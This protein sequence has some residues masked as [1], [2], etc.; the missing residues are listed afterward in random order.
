MSTKYT[1]IITDIDPTLENAQTL[2]AFPPCVSKIDAYIDCKHYAKV[3]QG[4]GAV[5]DD[6]GVSLLEIDRTEEEVG[7]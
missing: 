7:V 4:F 6:E 1:V 5:Y 3:Y 2:I